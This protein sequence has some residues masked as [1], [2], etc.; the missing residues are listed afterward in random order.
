MR[1]TWS[2]TVSI[3]FLL[4][5]ACGS[6]DGPARPD[7]NVAPVEP[8]GPEARDDA[9]PGSP[10][11]SPDAGATV[12]NPDP[13]GSSK[14]Q[15][16][17]SCATEETASGRKVCVHR[18]GLV[19]LRVTLPADAASNKAPL[20][21]AV[22]L[23]GDGAA[24][25]KNNGA[26][27]ALLPWI[28]ENHAV[29]VS[30]LAPNGCSWWREPAYTKCTI[31]DAQAA[32]HRDVMEEN[33]PAFEAAVRAVRAAYDIQNEA[34]FYYGSSG[35]SMFLTGSFVPKYGNRYPGAFA[36]NCGGEKPWSPFTWSTTSAVER[37]ATKL[38]F[39][40]GA[41]D[42]ALIP[43]LA[44]VPDDFAAR[45]FAVDDHYVD[46]QTAHCAFEGGQLAHA[47]TQEVWNTYLGK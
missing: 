37:G 32:Q 19:E 1:P 20:A 26:A 6:G 15:G 8:E 11:A 25:H 10:D 33:A 40:Y 5:V 43:G 14:G 18:S 31:D 39:T 22:Y 27:R 29:F 46:A 7:T 41:K 36:L 17:L 3:V 34:V 42:E 9:G 13:T 16:G 47:H 30:A 2:S 23:H 38:F 35:G 28:D 45:G 24:A 4:F 12:G 44:D 21:L